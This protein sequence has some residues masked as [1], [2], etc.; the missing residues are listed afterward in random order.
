MTV[1]ID[2]EIDDF[3][4]Y[5]AVE[6]LLS[7][8]QRVSKKSVVEICKEYLKGSGTRFSMEPVIEHELGDDYR[9]ID[10]DYIDKVFEMV[11]KK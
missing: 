9:N 6:Y 8:G 5:A 10:P 3:M 4:A 2:F 1:R 7:K 11:W